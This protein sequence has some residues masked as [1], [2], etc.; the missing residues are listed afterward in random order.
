MME[1]SEVAW[2]EQNGFPNWEGTSFS[3]KQTVKD[4]TSEGTGSFFLTDDLPVVQVE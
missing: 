2:V 4:L 3:V 1:C